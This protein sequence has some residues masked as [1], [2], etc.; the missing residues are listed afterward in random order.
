[1]STHTYSPLKSCFALK[2]RALIL[3]LQFRIVCAQRRQR[4]HDVYYTRDIVSVVVSYRVFRGRR[5]Y[6]VPMYNIS[7]SRCVHLLCVMLCGAL[8]K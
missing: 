7:S 5:M 3:I 1:M 2:S 8:Y 6:S 4:K